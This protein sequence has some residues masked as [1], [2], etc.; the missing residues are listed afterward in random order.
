MQGIN[1][2]IE[3]FKISNNFD[4]YIEAI[5]DFSKEYEVEVEE[6]VDNLDTQLKN[7]VKTEFIK[8]NYFPNKKIEASLDDFLKD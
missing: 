5:V 6:I 2:L 8:L 7:K 4:T 3:R 1:L